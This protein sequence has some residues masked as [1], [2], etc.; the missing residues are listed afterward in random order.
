M[1]FPHGRG[2]KG[3]VNFI[4]SSLFLWHLLCRISFRPRDPEIVCT[5]PL[6]YISFWRVLNWR[7]SRRA[8]DEDIGNLI[9][10]THPTTPSHSTPKD[11]IAN[12]RGSSRKH[13]TPGECVCDVRHGGKENTRGKHQRTT[14]LPTTN[15][16]PTPE[17]MRRRRVEEE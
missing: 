9:R 4:D 5:S 6:S 11:P 8:W 14:I 16:F 3:D 12:G 1:F 7:R 17:R 10:I 13:C 15:R 2:E